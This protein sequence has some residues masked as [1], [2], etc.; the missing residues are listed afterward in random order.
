MV[1]GRDLCPAHGAGA[2][3]VGDPVR[4]AGEVEGVGAAGEG[5]EGER[6]DVPVRACG[7]ADDTGGHRGGGSG[8]EGGVEKVVRCRWWGYMGG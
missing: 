2:R 5:A 3:G 8:V 4:D 7:V 6:G 1:E